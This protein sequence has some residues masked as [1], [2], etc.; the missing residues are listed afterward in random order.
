MSRACDKS[1]HAKIHRRVRIGL[2]D[3]IKRH[4][5][6]KQ[7]EMGSESVDETTF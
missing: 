1:Q 3:I 6:K 7:L 4:V 5:I 2:E